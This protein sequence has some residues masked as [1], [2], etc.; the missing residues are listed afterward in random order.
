MANKLLE[1][2]WYFIKDTVGDVGGFFKYVTK[3]KTWVAIWGLLSIISLV[4][5]LVSKALGHTPDYKTFLFTSFCFVVF[6][7]TYLWRIFSEE[8]THKQREKYKKV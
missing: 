2:I 6:Y 5:A 3:E 8:Y 1:F 4:V 7:I